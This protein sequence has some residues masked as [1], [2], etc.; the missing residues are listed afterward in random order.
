MNVW[1]CHKIVSLPGNSRWV[2]AMEWKG[3]KEFVASIEVPFEVNG[4]EAGLL[5]SH[6]PLSFLKVPFFIDPA[7]IY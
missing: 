2:Q 7:S 3:Q 5:R 1:V 4:T 6:G